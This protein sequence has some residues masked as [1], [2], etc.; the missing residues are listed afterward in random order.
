MTIV[1]NSLKISYW[2]KNCFVKNSF[3]VIYFLF[4]CFMLLVNLVFSVKMWCLNI[5]QH[6]GVKRNMFFVL[7]GDRI[8]MEHVSILHTE[9]GGL[10]NK[11]C[12]TCSPC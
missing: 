10:F 6:F 4:F 1:V 7:Y 8:P 11:T 12:S 5:D 9:L 3:C 2:S